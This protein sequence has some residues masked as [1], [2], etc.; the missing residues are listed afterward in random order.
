MCTLELLPAMLESLFLIAAIYF[1]G[2]N[3]KFFIESIFPVTT[4]KVDYITSPFYSWRMK[5]SKKITN[6][7][8]F[9]PSIVNFNEGSMKGS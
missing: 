3:I 4:T 2:I 7:A 9:A 1:L 5:K 6:S 8:H